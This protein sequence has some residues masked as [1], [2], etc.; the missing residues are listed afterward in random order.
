MTTAIVNGVT[1]VVQD[2]KRSRPRGRYVR[3]AGHVL[4]VTGPLQSR[5]V[6]SAIPRGVSVPVTRWDGWEWTDTGEV[7]MGTKIRRESAS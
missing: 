5:S 4:A 1:L 3:I 7:V 6:A 2:D